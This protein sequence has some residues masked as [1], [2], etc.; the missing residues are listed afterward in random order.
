MNKNLR[1]RLRPVASRQNP[2]VKELRRAFARGETSTN[3]CC[4]IESVRLMEEAIRSGLKFR[5]LFF[6]QSSLV[7]A[8]RLLPQMAA[9]V[10]T[11]LLPNQVFD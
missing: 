8:D 11:V 3:G 5:A 6:R 9:Q 4:A 2:L 1:Q 10:E 7:L